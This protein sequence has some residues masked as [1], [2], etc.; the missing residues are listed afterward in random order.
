TTYDIIVRDANLCPSAA[1]QQ[2]ITAPTT[3]ITISGTQT[4]V[5]IFGQNTGAIDSNLSGGNGGYIYSWTGPNG[6]SSNKED[7]SG[8]FAGTYTLVVQD[9]R[10]GSTSDNAGCTTTT[11]FIITEPDELLVTIDYET[12]TSDLQCNGDDNARILAT[13][14]GG[15]APFSYSWSKETSLGSGVFTPLSDTSSLLIGADAG[16][17]RVTITDNSTAT[18]NAEFVITQPDPLDITFTQVDVDCFADPTGVIDITVAGGTPPYNYLWSNGATSE[19]LS[20]ISSGDYSVDV[21][22]ANGCP[23]SSTII[24]I[25][26]PIT[27]ISIS[28]TT[29]T[30]LTGFQTANGG[31]S[32]TVA[33]GTPGYTY[34]WRVDGTSTVIGTD[35]TIT[36]LQADTYEVTIMDANNCILTGTFIVTQPELLE[37]SDI[38]PDSSI[39]CFGDQTVSLT[40]TVIGGVA[41]YTYQWYNTLDNTTILSTTDTVMNLGAG[42]YEVAIMDANAN[43]ASDTFT[44]IEPPVLQASYTS[45]DVS[46]NAGNDAS[47]DLTVLGGTPPYAFFWSNGDNTQ[48]IS[49]LSAGTYTLTVRDA[50]LCE[51]NL[52]IDITE[53][54]TG[55]S[56]SNVDITDASGNALNNGS[57]QV[58]AA[59]GT[60]AYTY[61]WTDNTNTTVGTNSNLLNNVGAGSYFLTLMD[62]NG[63][64]L[65]PIEYIVAEPA[66]LLVTTTQTAIPC[67]GENGEL[68]A[69][70]TGGVP[71]YTYQWFDAGNTE[72]STTDTTGPI[73][74]GTYRVVVLDANSNQTEQININLTQPNLLEITNINITEVGCYNGTDGSITITVTGGTGNYT[75]QWNTLGSS[76]NTLSG[77]TAGDYNVM[78]SDENNCTTTSGTITVTQPVVYDITNVNIIRPSATGTT[79]GSIAISITGGVAPYTYQWTDNLGAVVLLEANV[80]N[81]S[82]TLAN[83]AEGTYNILVTDADGCTINDTYNLANPGELLVNINQTQQ[84]NCFGGSDGILEVITTGGVGGNNYQWFDAN[85]NTQIGNNNILNGVAVGDY[86]IIVSNAEGISEQSAV[87]NV[88]QP[89]AVIGNLVEDNPDCF[90]ANDGSITI[91]AAGGNGS[92]AYRYRILNGTYSAW[93]PFDNGVTTQIT[94]LIDGI[95]QIQLQDSNGCFYEDLGTIGVLSTTL[96]QPDQLL[97]GSVLLNDPTGFGLSNGSIITTTTGG[98]P[99]Y[100]YQWSDTNGVLT[101]T[102]ATLAGITAGTYTLLITD[103][104]GCQ[105]SQSFTLNQPEELVVSTEIVNIVLCNADTNG[106]I[107]AIT[108]GGIG[109]YTY[110]WFT[111]GNTTVIGT[112]AILSG[113]GA[114]SYYVIVTDSNNN[115]AQ[116]TTLQLT[117]PDALQLSLTADFILCG[118]GNDWNIQS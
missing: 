36:N 55:L 5:L 26:Q 59:G 66:P 7:I 100:T 98:T 70:V 12:A 3:P 16:N 71:P 14:S 35:A 63:C 102:S 109:T 77:I 8:L 34:Q 111:Q 50:N 93:I 99:P 56:I 28:N 57:I 4:N 2:P 33:G 73:P 75:Y 105:T 108:T 67:F 46:C 32:I 6:F 104:L 37:V 74:T 87:F 43:L 47:I 112:T 80:N 51:A 118:D 13:V 90:G 78:V 52:S 25:T 45:I 60:P 10:F 48:D 64:V 115:T 97:I 27:P 22:D 19:D 79:D 44:I 40:A 62:A 82:S 94:N 81:S 20:G 42:T 88:S 54:A 83:Q 72:I 23:I 1:Q 96:N 86:Y 58:T 84:I 103:A 9:N 41:P 92:Y 69:N 15:I 11:N 85:T 110:Q 101:E 24:T 30:N 76:T 29:I 89:L 114:G 116:S 39:L 65:G 49:G 61:L 18:T 91:T 68:L 53:P 106:S 38:Q 31:I 95:Y 117:Q 17:Y 107:R 113:V 21:T